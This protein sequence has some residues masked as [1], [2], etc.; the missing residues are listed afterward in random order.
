VF[1]YAD[2]QREHRATRNR[3]QES[4]RL[5]SLELADLNGRRVTLF[6]TVLTILVGLGVVPDLTNAVVKPAF[7]LL[8]QDSRLRGPLPEL[9]FNGI[10]AVGL[11]II[12]VLFCLAIFARKPRV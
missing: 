8:D 11:A 10:T 9:A 4:V 7:E 1:R 5:K 6:A 12:L 2:T 3:I